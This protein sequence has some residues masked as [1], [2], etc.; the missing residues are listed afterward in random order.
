MQTKEY[1]LEVGGKTLYAQF[2]D[3]ADQASGSV[4]IRYGN[5]VVLVTAVM[6]KSVREGGD[7]LPLTVAVITQGHRH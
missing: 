1:S 3:L 7:Y 6:S 5:T 2:T 4:I